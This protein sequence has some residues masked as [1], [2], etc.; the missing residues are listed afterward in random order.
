MITHPVVLSA[1]LI[2]IVTG[3]LRL[4]KSPSLQKIFHYL[5]APFWCYFVPVS[6]ASAGVLPPQSPVYT[7]LSTYVLCACLLLL[8]LN[9]NL[10]AIARLGPTALGAMAVG[11]IGISLGA[12]FAYK[13]FGR[14]LPEEA[15]KGVG[16]LSASWTGGSANMLAVKEALQMS[17]SGLAPFVIVDTVMTYAW[18]GLMIAL[19][20]WQSA[21]D[22]WVKADLGTLE[23]AAKRLTGRAAESQFSARRAMAGKLLLFAMALAV[24]WVC[25]R[26]G[27]LLPRY[28]S[29]SPT[30]WAYILISVL[31]MGLSFTTVSRLEAWGASKV[32]YFCLYLL[33]AA[34]GARAR[35]QDILHTPTL[36][37][38][39]LVLVATHACILMIYGYLRRVP[40]FFLVTASQANI[41][42]TASAPIV[43]G[44]YQAPLASVGLLLAI[45]ANVIGTYVGIFIAQAC[46]W[47]R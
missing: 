1:L 27:T 35:F 21:W 29:F 44:I 36:L 16:A 26:L 18:M 6:L 34:I 31:G 12:V 7:F 8:L 41:G 17:D 40:M 47:I 13:I 9:V 22:Q 38:L 2:A 25:L 20:P 15:W 37:V 43:A 5:P 4:E 28:P 45:A 11:M 10:P 32:G 24:A 39:A 19:A 14:W 42:G 33:L 46:R 23:D 30:A 3:I